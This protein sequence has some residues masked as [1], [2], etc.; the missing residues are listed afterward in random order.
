MPSTEA[1]TKLAVLQLRHLEPFGLARLA[2][3][4]RGAMATIARRGNH[5]FHMTPKLKFR[6]DLSPY[7]QLRQVSIFGSLWGLSG[8]KADVRCYTGSKRTRIL[9]FSPQKWMTRFSCFSTPPP[10][11]PPQKAPQRDH[12]TPPHCF[13]R[14][15]DSIVVRMGDV[16]RPE[17]A[18]AKPGER[19]E[20]PILSW[21]P[22]LTVTLPP[23]NMEVHRPL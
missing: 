17:P 8:V 6:F 10:S 16:F 3:M 18:L 21:S 22:N 20:G 4:H 15:L 12:P 14:S 5:S 13:P 23:A 1:T 7:A 9:F 19:P 11:P 2:Q